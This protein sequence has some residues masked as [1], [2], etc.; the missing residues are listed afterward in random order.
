VNLADGSLPVERL[1]HRGIGICIGSDS[2][3]RIDP[4]EELRELDGIARRQSG[5][6]DV[7][8]VDALL[9]IGSDEGAA[10]LGLQTWPE[11]TIDGSHAQLRDVE[12]PLC[13][14]V[15]SCSSAVVKG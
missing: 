5:R 14:L 2:N 12:E 10:S 3:V 1:L 13:A 7:L 11:I 9:S 4:F 8:T 6:R 15:A